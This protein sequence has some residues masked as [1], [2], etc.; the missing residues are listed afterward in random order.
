MNNEKWNTIPK[1]CKESDD[2][3]ARYENENNVEKLNQ[4]K[5][6]DKLISDIEN[7]FL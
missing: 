7:Q 1:A 6:F 4:L 3:K 5:D 2:L